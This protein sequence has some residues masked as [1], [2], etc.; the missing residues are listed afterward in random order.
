[1]TG[2]K[3]RAPDRP[4]TLTEDW[5]GGGGDLGTRGSILGSTSTAGEHAFKDAHAYERATKTMRRTSRRRAIRN[6]ND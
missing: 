1:M 5:K 4:P 2:G 3:K 6:P